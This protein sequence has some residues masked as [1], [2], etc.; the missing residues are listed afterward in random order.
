MF[1]KLFSF[2]GNKAEQEP[3]KQIQ[4]ARSV[5]LEG[6]DK[7]QPNEYGNYLYP[8]EKE[9][10]PSE[11]QEN[12]ARDVGVFI[13]QGACYIDVSAL[14][15]RYEENDYKAATPGFLEYIAS[16]GWRGS[17]LIG[18]EAMF[19]PV[20]DRTYAFEQDME[21]REKI[22]L[23]AYCAVK[24]RKGE[25]VGNLLKD[26]NKETYFAFADRVLEDEK[27]LASFRRL[28]VSEYY[29]PEKRTAI[30]QATKALK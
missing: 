15:S 12:Y 23:Y 8:P 14:L 5:Y 28:G 10:G 27:L 26:E 9:R 25:P 2:I 19:K 21:E 16:K 1:K 11:R 17:A 20:L 6:V 3:A 22:A 30:Y 29:A 7:A 13:P 18:Y 4:A 24:G